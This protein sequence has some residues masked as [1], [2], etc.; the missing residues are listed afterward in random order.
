MAT[1][2][3]A[4]ISARIGWADESV[5]VRGSTYPTARPARAERDAE[6]DHDAARGGRPA[7]RIVEPERA[8]GGA[9][10]RL[11]IDARAGDLRG[12]VLL[13]VGVQRERQQRPDEHQPG[14][15]D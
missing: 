9:D 10:E 12:N 11:E 6:Q 5:T 14:G 8:E 1:A 3:A 15:V 4:A 13:P 2:A 7:E